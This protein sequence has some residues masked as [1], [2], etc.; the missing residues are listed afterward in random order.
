MRKLAVIICIL[1]VLLIAAMQKETIPQFE[2]SNGLI[3]TRLYLPD[4]EKGYYRATR[5]DWSG[6]IASL[7][8]SGHNYFGQWFEKYSPTIHDAIMGPV[9]DFTPVG[10]NDAKPGGTFLKIGIGMISKP[11]ETQYTFSKTYQIVNNG[12]WEVKTKPDQVQFIHILKDTNY[13]YEYEKTI[14]LV[15]GKP[16]MVLTQTLKNRGIKPIETLVYD[17][18]FFVIDNQPVGPGYTAEFPYNISA[19]FR[20]GSDI[21]DVQDNHLFL[22][23]DLSK[24]ETIY[25]GDLQGYGTSNK[26]YEIKVENHI[27]GAGVMITCDQPLAKLVFWACP[28]AF[29]PEPYLMIKANPGKEFTWNIYYEFYNCEINKELK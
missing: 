7:E 16:V 23:R 15:K 12:S 8:Y 13:S 5:F 4:T 25:C 17:H 27:A 22:K 29:C 6:V 21:A 18:N 24:G 3:K 11:D 26:D 20:N 9:E 19:I 14:H 1:S 10:Y 28:T 2:I